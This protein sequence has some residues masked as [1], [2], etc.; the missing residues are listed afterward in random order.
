MERTRRP[1]LVAIGIYAL[2]TLAFALTSPASTFTGH[3]PYNH[4]A[5]LA[6]GWLHGRLDLGGPPPAYTGNNDFALF[7]GRHYVSFP[8]FPA[9]LIAP[10][11]WLNGSPERTRDGLFFLG[12]TGVAPAVLFLALEKLSRTGRSRRS[13]AENAALALL[14]ALGTVY[15]FTAVQGTVWFAAHVVGVALA[16]VYLYASIDAEHPVV[17]GLALALGSSTSRWSSS[18]AT[19]S[20]RLVAPGLPAT[21]ARSPASAFLVDHA[22]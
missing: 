13:T 22:R 3:T 6:D 15:W 2:A 18:C 8:P 4:Y 7:E 5:L 1:L 20:S 21:K 17:A 10:L 19:V 14:F 16:A 9:V 12:F 11:V